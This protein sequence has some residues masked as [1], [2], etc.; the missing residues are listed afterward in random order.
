MPP[1]YCLM[2]RFTDT[3]AVRSLHSQPGGMPWAAAASEF[4]RIN[5]QQESVI[6]DAERLIYS[7]VQA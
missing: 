7:V 1:R 4:R 5:A 6:G 2:V 3:T